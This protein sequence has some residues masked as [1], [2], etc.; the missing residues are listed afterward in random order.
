MN[1]GTTSC[2]ETRK[3]VLFQELDEETSILFHLA[4]EH[5]YGLNAAGARI[6]HALQETSDMETI[7]TQIAQEYPEV[8]ETTIRQ[9][10]TDLVEQ[11]QQAELA[12]SS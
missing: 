3:D 4:K 5:Y 8:E 1:N 11:L 10:L 9:D 12:T 2:I 6:W 7:V